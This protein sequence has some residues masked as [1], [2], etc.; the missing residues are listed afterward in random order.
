MSDIVRV[1]VSSLASG[2]LSDGAL[3]GQI[4]ESLHHK[5]LSNV[6]LAASKFVLRMDYDKADYGEAAWTGDGIGRGELSGA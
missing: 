4:N 6:Q 2:A 3:R 1:A 5:V